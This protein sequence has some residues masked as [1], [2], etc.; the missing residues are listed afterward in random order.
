MNSRVGR[1]CAAYALAKRLG[2]EALVLGVGL[3][4]EN[5]GNNRISYK[6]AGEP[7][8]PI[9]KP[10]DAFTKV[11]GAIG[12]GGDSD[13]DTAR[14][15]RDK[16]VLDVAAASL[17]RYRQRLPSE[18]WLKLDR[19]LESVRSLEQ[20]LTA[21]P[22]TLPD[23]EACSPNQVP[24]TS[25]FPASARKHIDVLTQVLACNV[26]RVV[27]LQLGGSG[28]GE[29]FGGSINWPSE[30][31][32][33]PMSQHVIA[34]D[35]DANRNPTTIARRETIEAT[36]YRTLAYLMSSLDAV[37]EG[38]G[39]MLD[40]TLILYCKGMGE[41]HAYNR[42]VLFMLAGRAGGALTT[43]RYLGRSGVPHNNL[44]VSV[45]NLLGL[46]DVESFG[47]SEF[48]GGPVSL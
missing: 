39:S 8:T 18:D 33:Y 34:H 47:E 35:Y 40:H 30:S 21:P 36:Y 22:P 28:G 1:F 41:N 4:S 11:F 2:G 16:S 3:E 24:L 43:N 23:T 9:W 19:H 42:E 12:G 44:L 10:R 45:C 14:R 17:A 15:A 7:V 27:T 20:K 46:A 29:T 25:D 38:D 31:I 37:P 48:C 32:V 26:E 13:A 5:S 6:A